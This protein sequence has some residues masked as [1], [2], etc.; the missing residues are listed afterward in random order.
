MQQMSLIPQSIQSKKKTQ[1]SDILYFRN[2]WVTVHLAK[3]KKCSNYKGFF[4][5]LQ[6]LY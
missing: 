4:C 3:G 1:I 2:L 5:K 6:K